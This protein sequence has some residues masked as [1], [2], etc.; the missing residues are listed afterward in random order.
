MVSLV[1]ILY[2]V[3]DVCILALGFVVVLYWGKKGLL[4]RTLWL[5]VI[6]MLCYAIGDVLWLVSSEA[7]GMGLVQSIGEDIFEFQL[8]DIPY[9]AACLI[10]IA[11]FLFPVRHILRQPK[12]Q[13]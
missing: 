11:A 12:M 2:I 1:N 5:L 3:L 9:V 10:W 6:G 13:K 7:G 8:A 4:G